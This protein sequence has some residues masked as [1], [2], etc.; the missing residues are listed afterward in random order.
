MSFVFA[1]KPAGELRFVQAVLQRRAHTDHPLAALRGLMQIGNPLPVYRLTVLGANH[2]RPLSR[3]RPSG[4]RYPVMGETDAAMVGVRRVRGRLAFDGVS[5]GPFVKGLF[6]AATHAEA[7]L[8]GHTTAYQLRLLEIPTRHVYLLW[9]HARGD[10]RFVPLTGEKRI[11]TD[12]APFLSK[13]YRRGRK[14]SGRQ[15]RS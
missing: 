6:V 1:P 14:R 3:A 13:Q 8:T 11:E 4:W 2:K 5:D 7:E 12:I 10:N 9:L 15:K